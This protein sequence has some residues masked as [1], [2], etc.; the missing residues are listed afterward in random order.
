MKKEIK[1][2]AMRYLDNLS[3]EYEHIDYELNHE[4]ISAVDLAN[5]NYS[6]IKTVYNTLAV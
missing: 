2:N 3:I 4:F 1:T 5:E 6:D